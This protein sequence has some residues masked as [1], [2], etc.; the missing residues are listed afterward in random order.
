MS[1]F[2]MQN[3]TLD[4]AMAKAEDLDAEESRLFA[5]MAAVPPEERTGSDWGPEGTFAKA[6]VSLQGRRV[7]A[8]GA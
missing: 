2:K 8:G 7:E 3:A 1:D 6:F 4:A 5:E